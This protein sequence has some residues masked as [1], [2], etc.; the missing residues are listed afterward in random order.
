[1]QLS[2][3]YNNLDAKNNRL[4]K[5]LVLFISLFIVN[6]IAKKNGS[7]GGSSTTIIFFVFELILIIIDPVY[8]FIYSFV[9]HVDI[10]TSLADSWIQAFSFL[11]MFYIF[12][13]HPKSLSTLLEDIKLK[14]LFNLSLVLI[15]YV[16]FIN[17]G[18]K[19]G[20]TIEN[21]KISFGYI[22]GFLTILPAYYFTLNKPKD[23]FIGLFFVTVCFL[24]VYYLDIIKGYGIFKLE[25]Y[26]HLEES[27][28]ER[29]AGYDIRQ[30]MIFFTYLI[31]AS[32]LVTN[33][34]SIN[35]YLLISI[36]IAAYIILVLAF[37]R[38]AMFYVLMGTLLS[39]FSI[40]KYA[41]TKNVIKYVIGFIVLLF[42]AGLFFGEYIT[43]IRNVFEIALNY[44]SGKGG[45][46]SADARFDLQLPILSGHFFNDP[47][48]GYGLV[49]SVKLFRVGMMGFVDFPVLGTITAYG[50]IGMSIYYYK[51]FVLL[52]GTKMN[53][54]D[55]ELNNHD[56]FIF[57]LNLTLRAYIVTMI[58]FRFF[59]ISWEFTFDY[60]QAEFGL[61]TGVFLALN[62]I[63]SQEAQ[64]EHYSE[65]EE[66]LRSSN[67]Y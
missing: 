11:F 64:Q 18:L 39:Y 54:L 38:L 46:A 48:T 51:F 47:F 37:Y 8:S 12:I 13:K 31:P 5:L 61:F 34:K 65:N 30:F 10:F 41:D 16:V 63:L 4:F 62:N 23:L 56:P 19:S 14:K 53:S 6:Y 25:S 58:T 36:G 33:L 52:T 40:K 59:Y 2:I 50:I 9:I 28:M 57:Y 49:E 44:F 66:L 7:S 42:T 1:M 21:I 32:L 20:F 26:L 17:V 45:D 27:T 35:K 67:F 55:M 60:Q 43:E 3:F 24:F 29:L 15:I 22:F